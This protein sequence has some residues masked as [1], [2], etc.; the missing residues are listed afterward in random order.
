VDFKELPTFTGNERQQPTYSQVENRS[1]EK[2]APTVA[3][4]EADVKSGKSISLMD[5]ATAIN[6]APERPPTQKGKQD[7]LA[8]I[9]ANKQRV[10]QASQPAAQKDN[11]LE[12]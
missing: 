4:L 2:H 5:L 9:A 12:V 7:F 11:Q 6:N 3:D 10:A 1:D 8:K